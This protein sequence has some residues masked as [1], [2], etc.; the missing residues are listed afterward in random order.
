LNAVLLLLRNDLKRD[1]KRPWSTL[2]FA[3]LPLGLSLLIASVFGGGSKS[4]PMP[5]LHVA[6]LDEDKDMLTRILRSLPTQGDAAKNLSLQFVETREEGL[7]LV[8]KNKVSALVVLPEHLTEDLLKGQTN[9][10]VLFENPAQQIM[11]KIVRQGVSM[12]ALGLSSAAEV[13]GG[14]LRD[15]R[16]MARSNG[17]PAEA[18]VGQLASS[19]VRKLGNLR[20]YLFPPIVQFK[21]VAAEDFIPLSTNAPPKL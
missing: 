16:E 15:I 6:I 20:P 3:A 18:A 7:R 11:P 8:E 1:W 12:M 2:L 9:S 21:T 13:L 17:F 5:T 10:L 14:P 19:S 4:G